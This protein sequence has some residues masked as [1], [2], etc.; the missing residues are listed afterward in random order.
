[1]I[2]QYNMSIDGVHIETK[3]KSLKC[4]CDCVNVPKYNESYTGTT[5]T[6]PIFNKTEKV[7]FSYLLH[8]IFLK[9]TLIVVAD[10]RDKL[11]NSDIFSLILIHCCYHSKNFTIKI[12]H[13]LFG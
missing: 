11:K 3:I 10:Q 8:I 13:I 6:F 7:Y 1:M 12:N 5:T 4:L 9:T 2:V